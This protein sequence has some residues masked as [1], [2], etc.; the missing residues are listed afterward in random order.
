MPLLG[1]YHCWSDDD[2][3]CPVCLYDDYAIIVDYHLPN[4]TIPAA[5]CEVPLQWF[6]SHQCNLFIVKK[7]KLWEKSN[8]QCLCRLNPCSLLVGEGYRLDLCTCLLLLQ[9]FCSFTPKINCSFVSRSLLLCKVSLALDRKLFRIPYSWTPNRHQTDSCY[10][11]MYS[12]ECDRD[13]SVMWT[14]HDALPNS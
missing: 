2:I 9:H 5:V 14:V 8:K 11:V 3:V 13:H 12:S 10:H 1:T 7:V 4:T 6:I